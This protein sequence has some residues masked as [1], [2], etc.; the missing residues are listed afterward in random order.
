M[1]YYSALKGNEL[2]SYGKTQ[3]KSKCVLLSERSQSEKAMYWKKAKAN[4]LLAK[5][6][7]RRMNRQSTEDFRAVKLFC[8][9]LKW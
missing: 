3:R 1:T 4:R 6:M 5:R 2:S 7:E 8:E 9:M